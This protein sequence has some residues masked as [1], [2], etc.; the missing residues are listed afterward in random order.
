MCLRINTMRKGGLDWAFA[1]SRPVSQISVLQA[2]VISVA[3][4]YG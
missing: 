2:E 3:D 1:M 4:D